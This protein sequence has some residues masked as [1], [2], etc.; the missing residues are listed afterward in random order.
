MPQQKDSN[1]LDD[2]GE[3]FKIGAAAR[4]LK[5]TP[6]T[7]RFYEEIG[8]LAPGRSPGKTRSYTK[9]DIGRIQAIQHLTDLG[10]GL[11]DVVALATT[12]SR[13]KT[14]DSASHKVYRLLNEIQQV[15]ETKRN[16]CED[17]LN[18]IDVAVRLVKQCFGCQALPRYGRCEACIVARNVQNAHLLRLIWDRDKP[19]GAS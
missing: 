17:L 5:T 15:V 1:A 9:E 14:G 16:Q 11:H 8:I 18:Q 19:S 3:V 6:R 13:S 12:R 4:L 7:L 2:V 10:I